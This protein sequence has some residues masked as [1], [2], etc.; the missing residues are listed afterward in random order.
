MCALYSYTSGLC[1]DSCYSKLCA[2]VLLYVDNV[3]GFDSHIS[4]LIEYPQDLKSLIP[5]MD[6]SYFVF[7]VS[8]MFLAHI[9]ETVIWAVDIRRH[10]SSP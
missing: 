2:F 7:S 6:N 4:P 1:G 8:L 9:A 3:D 10:S 5:Q